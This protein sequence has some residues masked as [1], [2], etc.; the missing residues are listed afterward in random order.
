MEF[1][2]LLSP[3]FAGLASPPLVAFVGGGGKTAAIFA[4]ASSA[5]RAGFKVM[6]STSA[7]M[8]DPRLEANR[9]IDGFAI[10][11]GLRLPATPETS[12]IAD[13]FF[14]RKGH[15]C[16]LASEVLEA[17]GKVRGPHLSRFDMLKSISDL[18]L[19][20][21]DGSRGLPIK[22]PGPHE[23]P[24]PPATDIVIGLVGLDC[25][26]SSMDEEHVHRADLFRRLPGIDAG[27]AID[28][29]TIFDLVRADEGL[30]K[31]SP[32]NARHVLILNKGDSIDAEIRAGVRAAVEGADLP[33]D[34]TLMSSF[35]GGEARFEVLR[36]G[37]NSHSRST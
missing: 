11:P 30:F 23:P 10:E 9:D 7:A 20:E 31:N 36:G 6:I 18:L 27:N 29:S 32:P 33:V 21:A 13:T 25:I 3:F 4:L 26:G 19:V 5:K 28:I 1:F 2:S 14:P 37:R 8:R 24:V 22:A 17:E 35:M 16:F 34:L 15:I 12:S